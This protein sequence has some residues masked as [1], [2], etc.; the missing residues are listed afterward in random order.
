MPLQDPDGP[1]V[2]TLVVRIPFFVQ[3]LT[4]YVWIF[5]VAINYLYSNVVEIRV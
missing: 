2:V 3:P 1:Q 5:S 4:A